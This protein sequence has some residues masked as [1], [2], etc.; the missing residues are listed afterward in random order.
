MLFSRAQQAVKRTT[1]YILALPV[2]GR[3]GQLTMHRACAIF[4]R[5]RHS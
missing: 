5:E 4:I 3:Q 2:K 1:E